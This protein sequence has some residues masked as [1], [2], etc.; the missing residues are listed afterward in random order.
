MFGFTLWHVHFTRWKIKSRRNGENIWKGKKKKSFGSQRSVV[1][2]G[3]LAKGHVICNTGF[4]SQ[5]SK[6]EWPL[7]G[8][9]DKGG[10]EGS[11]EE[12][13]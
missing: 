11:G 4:M 8:I 1:G 9:A 13:G 2:E 3:D 10:G 5:T 7:Q 12:L 6:V